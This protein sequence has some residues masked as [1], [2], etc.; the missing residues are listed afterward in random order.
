M[1]YRSKYSG[2]YSGLGTMVSRPWLA[3]PCRDAAVKIMHEAQAV[4]P[5]GDPDEDR[6]P[7]L[8]RSS[9]SIESV[10]KNIPFRG[11]PRLRHGAMVVNSAPHAKAV[12]Y[13]DWNVP[14]YAPLT[15]AYLAV[16]AVNRG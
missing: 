13:G 15:K 3:K 10:F 8:Y 7:G 14:R 16:T 6:H 12:E 11:K 9:F 5:V 4:S 1:A 2:R